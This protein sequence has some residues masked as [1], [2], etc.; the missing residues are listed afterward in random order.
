MSSVALGNKIIQGLDIILNIM[1]K[2]G[3][4]TIIEITDNSEY[5]CEW[6]K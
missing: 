1:S 3:K 5:I 4:L 2:T 6:V